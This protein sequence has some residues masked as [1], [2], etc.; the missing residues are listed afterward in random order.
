[1]LVV[2][3][4]VKTEEAVEITDDVILS[5]AKRLI[6]NGIDKKSAIKQTAQELNIQK[7]IVYA[8]VTENL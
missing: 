4:Y 5:H 8:L 6:E 2:E 3:G 1:V 7:R